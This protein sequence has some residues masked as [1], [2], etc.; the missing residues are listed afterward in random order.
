MKRYLGISFAAFCSLLLVAG[1]AMAKP[2]QT[3]QVSEGE[4]GE[5]MVVGDVDGTAPVA[6]KALQD[7]VWIADWSFDGGSGCTSSQGG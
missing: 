6:A 4:L 3:H 1:F 2:T 7:T 5:S